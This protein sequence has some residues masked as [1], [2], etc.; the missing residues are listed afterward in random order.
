MSEN[1]ASGRLSL[2]A[3]CRRFCRDARCCRHIADIPRAGT[4]WAD[5]GIQQPGFRGGTAPRGEAG[6]AQ[7]S[8]RTVH[9]DRQHI[10]DPQFRMRFDS[11]LPIDANRPLRDQ[12]GTIGARAHNA[13]TPQPFVQALPVPVLCIRY[14][15]PPRLRAASAANGPPATRMGA[16][17]SGAGRRRRNG[18]SIAG[19]GGP[20]W[21]GSSAAAGRTRKPS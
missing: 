19:A 11:R 8:H 10:P 21:S 16:G 7:D 14:R 5:I 15:A 17:S 12:P 13:G 3:I 18:V 9:R 6:D 20:C 2:R 4:R 1:A